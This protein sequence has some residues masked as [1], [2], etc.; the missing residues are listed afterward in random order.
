MVA[1]AAPP[2]RAPSPIA[3]EVFFARLRGRAAARDT[4]GWEEKD[5]LLLDGCHP[6]QRA[7]ALDTSKRIVLLCGGRAGKTTLKKVRFLRRMIRKRGAKCLFIAKSATSAEDLMWAQLKETCE[8][9]GFAAG[10]DV[11]YTEDRLRCTLMKNGSTL[12]LVGADDTAEIDKLRGQPFDEVGIDEAASHKPELLQ[13]LIEQAVGPRLGDYR[14]TLVLGGT[15][16]S[17]LRGLF[18]ELTMNGSTKSRM[19]SERDQHPGWNGWSMHKWN[20]KMAAPYAE[21]IANAWAEALEQKE[22]NGWSDDHPAWRREYLGEWAADDTQMVFRYRSEVDGELWNQWDPPRDELGIAQLPKARGEWHYSIGMDL[23]GG[24]T[25]STGSSVKNESVKAVGDPT[26]IEIFAW[27]DQDTSKTLWHV[28]ELHTLERMYPRKLAELFLGEAL[29]HGRPEGL[30]GRLGWPDA[31][32]AD[33]GSLG[34]LVLEELANTYGIAIEPARYRDRHDA[35]ESF[36]GDLIDGRLKVLKGSVLET[37]LMNLQWD[38]DRYGMLAKSK[39]QRDDAA[40]AACYARAKAAH[41]LAEAQ[42]TQPKR[43]SA[44]ERV[45]KEREPV[46][47]RGE[48][49][50][51]LSED[52]GYYDEETW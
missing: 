8:R 1:V 5:R 25:N 49:D 12:R 42:A 6:L 10:V 18:Y 21:R 45:G 26:A 38:L 23:G 44:F 41:L 48:F 32:I 29:D 28:F 40:D 27:D 4:K 33:I 9:L 20:M 52:S 50:D 46:P 16:G 43:E 47:V 11:R 2:A 31:M 3:R 14:G 36:N 34:G 39:R 19:W 24:R 13:Y 35:I 7:A 15:P 30:F 51:I 22:M 17:I 37:Q